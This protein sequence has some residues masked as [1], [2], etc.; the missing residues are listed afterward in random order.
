MYV[1]LTHPHPKTNEIISKSLI[2]KRVQIQFC[3]VMQFRRSTEQGSVTST[4]FV[5]PFSSVRQCH[6]ISTFLQ[7]LCRILNSL[8]IPYIFKTV[9]NFGQSPSDFSSPIAMSID[10]DS[11]HF[12]C[13]IWVPLSSVILWILR[14]YFTHLRVAFM[15]MSSRITIRH[16]VWRPRWYSKKIL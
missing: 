13:F 16:Q 2:F 14:Q 15:W 7:E 1:Q 6:P 4:N 12:I 10:I 9:L 5:S 3:N 11:H 8:V